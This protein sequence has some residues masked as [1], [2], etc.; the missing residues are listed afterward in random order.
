MPLTPLALVFAIAA[1]L[2]V[3]PFQAP[4]A[5][6][7]PLVLNVRQVHL[8]PD[9][10]SVVRVGLLRYRVGLRL[11]S[12][13]RHFGGLSGLTFA[14]RDRLIAVSDRG[15]WISFRVAEEGGRLVGIS[16]ATIDAMRNTRGA[17]IEH[18]SDRD[19]EAVETAIDGS[20][21]V[22]F[23][24]RHRLWRYPAPPDHANGRATQL[25]DHTAW[26]KLPLNGGF[27]AMTPLPD[28]RRLLVSEGA[29][30]EARGRAGWLLERGRYHRLTYAPIGLFVPT[31]FAR[32]PCGD[33]LALERLFTAV[34]GFAGRLQI[35][36]RTTIR[37]GARLTGRQVALFERPLLIENYE[38]VAVRATP[39]GSTR[40]YVIS[41]DNYNP[42]QRTLLLAFE[43]I[44]SR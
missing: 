40:I 36:D 32:L 41:N 8:H 5:R 25:Q 27:E 28:E 12:R 14:G 35:I 34:G 2:L 10:P 3:L 4:P 6:A 9:K 15:W 18:K 20:L 21:L 38:G 16:D 37:P 19:A 31:D 39:A 43:L 33:V 23:E 1:T 17:P 29:D 11:T 22:T 13:D 44:A 7:D 26:R 42:L 30:S 24:R